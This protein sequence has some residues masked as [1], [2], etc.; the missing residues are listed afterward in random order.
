MDST[1]EAGKLPAVTGLA[2]TEFQVGDWQAEGEAAQGLEVAA[3]PQGSRR[4]VAEKAVDSAARARAIAGQELQ[5][6]WGAEVPGLGWVVGRHML[7][8]TAV[9]RV[10]AV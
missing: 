5:A 4:A 10:P 3:P 7:W 9:R 8:S 2:D 1:A 6:G